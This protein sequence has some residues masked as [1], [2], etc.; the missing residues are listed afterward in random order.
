MELAAVILN[1]NNTDVV[2]QYS[3]YYD[4]PSP[5]SPQRP[6]PIDDHVYVYASGELQNLLETCS[7]AIERWDYSLGY[8]RLRHVNAVLGSY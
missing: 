1:W 2:V 6:S 3:S 7:F 8:G 4:M 5:D